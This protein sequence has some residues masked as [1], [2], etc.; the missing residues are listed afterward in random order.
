MFQN[1]LSYLNK[2]D[3]SKPLFLILKLSGLK[4]FVKNNEMAASLSTE[5]IENINSIMNGSYHRFESRETS[6]HLINLLKSILKKSTLQQVNDK[7]KNHFF[8]NFIEFTKFH[9]KSLSI[10]LGLLNH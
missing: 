8:N 7:L 9:M 3:E 5:L 2:L 1:P 6:L 10:D 4:S